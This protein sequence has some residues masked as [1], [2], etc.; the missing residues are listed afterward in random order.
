VSSLVGVEFFT[1]A[2]RRL[3]AEKANAV[4]R[5]GLRDLNSIVCPDTLLRWHRQLVAQKWTFVRRRRP[6]RPRTKQELAALVVKMATETRNWGYTRIQGAMANLG[7]KLGRGTIG[8]I[9]K[10][11]GIEPA[12]ERGKHMPWSVFL[13][14]HWKLFAA[15]DFFSVEVW[16][17]HGLVTHFAAASPAWRAAQLL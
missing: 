9:L 4:G 6:G 8:R 5:K 11:A 13:K 10:D 7:H 17:W 12:P 3:L 14:A 16:G 2:Q 1:D 15:S